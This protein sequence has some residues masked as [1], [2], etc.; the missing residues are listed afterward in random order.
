MRPMTQT[1][2]VAQVRSCFEQ[3]KAW[4]VLV[5]RLLARAGMYE[6]SVLEQCAV[7]DLVTA[8]LGSEE[9]VDAFDARLRGMISQNPLGGPKGTIGPGPRS[10][11][12]SHPLDVLTP[13]STRVSSRPLGPPSGLTGSGIV[14]E[15]PDGEGRNSVA[16]DS[17]RGATPPQEDRRG[18][19]ETDGASADVGAG[20]QGIGESG[21]AGTDRD[22][23]QAGRSAAQPGRGDRQARTPG[24][25]GAPGT[26]RRRTGRPAAGPLTAT[27]TS[28]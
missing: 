27:D 20:E 28:R 14:A 25:A 4:R 22:G 21:S 5:G 8:A 15:A 26:R 23:G 1:E 9:F 2:Y 6:A 16:P 18:A 17:T 19:D 7:M 10:P 12:G 24:G 11:A 3:R 13:S